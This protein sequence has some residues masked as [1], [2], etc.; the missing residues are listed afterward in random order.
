MDKKV[1]NLKTNH[2]LDFSKLNR[3]ISSHMNNNLTFTASDEEKIYLT[4]YLHEDCFLANSIIFVHGF[5]G[6]MIG[7]LFLI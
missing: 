3:H 6:F 1:N 7:V 2:F 5:K 4:T